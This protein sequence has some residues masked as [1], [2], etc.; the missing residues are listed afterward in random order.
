MCNFEELPDARMVL[1]VFAR[2]YSTSTELAVR[3]RQGLRTVRARLTADLL[4]EIEAQP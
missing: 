3:W 2:S 1:L 4:I